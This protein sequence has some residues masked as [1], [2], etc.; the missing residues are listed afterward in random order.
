[1]VEDTRKSHKTK[2][3][4]TWKKGFLT[5]DH[6]KIRNFTD[7][8]VGERRLHLASAFVE[9]QLKTNCPTLCRDQLQRPLDSSH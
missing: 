7:V 8:S 6:S 1:M 3:R 2:I 5:D 4:Q 9:W